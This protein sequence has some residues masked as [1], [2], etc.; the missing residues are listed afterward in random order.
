MKLR[1]PAKLALDFFRG[2]DQ[3]RRIACAGGLFDGVD[4]SPGDFAAGGNHF[5]NAGAA[6]GA[7][8]V[9]FAL[10]RAQ[11]QNVRPRKIDNVDVV[12]NAGAVRGLII[13]AVN[14][15]VRFLTERDFEHVWNQ[16]RSRA[17]DL[18]QNLPDAPAAL[19]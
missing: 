10:G 4:L 7:K 16:M 14:F 12:A 19:K 5:T 3:P 11:S 8:I 2:S 17:G 1:L 18:R 15:H 13:G 9:K 6:A